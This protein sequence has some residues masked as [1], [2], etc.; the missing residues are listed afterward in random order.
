MRPAGLS[1]NTSVLDIWDLHHISGSIFEPNHP[2]EEANFSLCF[3]GLISSG[4]FAE[5]MAISEGSSSGRAGRLELC[6][7]F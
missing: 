5:L 2:V 6:L 3:F 1:L 7:P 4:H